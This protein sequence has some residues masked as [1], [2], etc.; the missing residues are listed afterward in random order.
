VLKAAL[1]T[2]PLI[3]FM[4]WWT[5]ATM[6]EPGSRRVSA[7]LLPS[8]AEVSQSFGSLWVDSALMRNIVKSLTRVLA[9]FAIAA[10]IAVP[11]GIAMG[12]FSR[13]G[14]TFSLWA[15]LLSYLPIAAIVP[16]T[17]IW[18]GGGEKQKIGF[19]ALATFAYLLPLVVRQLT[20]VDHQYLLSAYAQG[21]S[22]WQIVGRVLVPIAL[23]GIAGGCRLCLGVGWTYIVLAEVM[24]EGDTVGGVGN[25]IGTFGRL[26]MMEQIYLTLVAILLVGLV[27]DQ[28]CAWLNRVLFPYRRGLTGEE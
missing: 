4:L 11:L 16:I 12:S 6:G 13:V 7:I 15:T 17:M 8:P 2:V 21:A 25:L 20:A 9:G 28:V 10:A 14:A 19:L 22:V 27:L 18:W 24:R 3:V 26:G 5:W 1:A 23:P